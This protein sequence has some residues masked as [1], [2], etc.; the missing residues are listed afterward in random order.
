[1][2]LPKNTVNSFVKVFNAN[3]NVNVVYNLTLGCPNGTPLVQSVNFKIPSF[4]FQIRSG[5]ASVSLLK[6]R[7]DSSSL[8]NI[9]LFQLNLKATNQYILVITLDDFGQ[10]KLLLLDETNPNAGFGQ[11]G[12]QDPLTTLT[13]DNTLETKMR[14]INF[15]SSNID[16]KKQPDINISSVQPNFI[17]IYKNVTACGPAGQLDT[18]ASYSSGNIQ[19]IATTSLEVAEHYSTFIFDSANQIAK[20]TIIAPPI[21]LDQP[22]NGMSMVRVINGTGLRD[23][24]NITLGARDASSILG[25]GSG[26]LVAH[27]V[28]TGQISIQTLMNPGDNIPLTIYTSTE[29]ARLLFSGI[30][31]FQANKSYIIAIAKYTSGQIVA[32]IIEDNEENVIPQ[33]IPSGV[34]VQIVNAYSG[35]NSLQLSLSSM[36]SKATL[37][38]ASSLATVLPF[39]TVNLNINNNNFAFDCSNK[40]DTSVLIVLYSNNGVMNALMAPAYYPYKP[41]TGYW[42]LRFINVSNSN[43]LNV[44]INDK[45]SNPIAQ[46]IGFGM[47]STNPTSD[48]RDRNVSLLFY[49]EIQDSIPIYKVEDIP[50]NI[51][52]NYTIIINNSFDKSYSII[53]QQEF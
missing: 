13:P 46:N 14:T 34:F 5:G 30:T 26:E 3:P 12:G 43:E 42:N 18:I 35:S 37:Y 39:G 48:N 49:K 9:G 1:M 22:V 33:Q 53:T 11:I 31:K 51:R 19:S 10:E 27:K 4:Q 15:S 7:T 8:Q 24:L 29:P 16:L 23:S 40:A 41:S 38:N 50:L 45:L 28:G 25:Y 44:F 32:Y 36:L 6:S 21:H 52:K 17:D 20:Y 47:T 2:G